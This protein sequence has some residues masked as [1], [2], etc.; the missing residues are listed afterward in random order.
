MMSS[1]KT[2][3]VLSFEDSIEDA[4]GGRG[5]IPG[6]LWLPPRRTAIPSCLRVFPPGSQ[7]SISPFPGSSQ[8]AQ[9]VWIALVEGAVLLSTE[10]KLRKS[11]APRSR[12]EEKQYSASPNPPPRPRPLIPADT[13]TLLAFLRFLPS[14]GPLYALHRT[15]SSHT[16][17]GPSAAP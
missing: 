15:R 17:W 10:Q 5:P 13:P 12:C 14:T 2:V 1:R 11:K 4:T 3:T 7:P 16:L 9:H 6:L 8:P